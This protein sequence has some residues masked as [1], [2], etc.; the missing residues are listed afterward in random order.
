VIAS[1]REAHGNARIMAPDQ[2]PTPGR[3]PLADR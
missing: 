3:M 2:Y 1:W